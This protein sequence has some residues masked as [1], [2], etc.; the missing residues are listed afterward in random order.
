M[1]HINMTVEIDICFDD[2]WGSSRAWVE[3]EVM[4]KIEGAV[5]DMF[6]YPLSTHAELQYLDFSGEEEESCE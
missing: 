1:T 4:R 2:E 6:E 3:N 5:S